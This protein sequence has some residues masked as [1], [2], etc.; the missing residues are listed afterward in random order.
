MKRKT[1]IKFENAKTKRKNKINK[2]IVSIM[3]IIFLCS[4]MTLSSGSWINVIIGS[5]SGIYIGI[6]L[7]VNESYL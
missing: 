3:A 7:Y 5:I 1:K 6:Y 2:A 4:C